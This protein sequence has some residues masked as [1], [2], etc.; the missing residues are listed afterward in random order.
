[1]RRYGALTFNGVRSAKIFA[2]TATYAVVTS[3]VITGSIWSDTRL[4][5]FAIHKR[6]DHV[7]ANRA[8]AKIQCEWE[9]PA[10]HPKTA[11]PGL[12]HARQIATHTQRIGRPALPCFPTEQIAGWP[13][14]PTATAAAGNG[15]TPPPN[16]LERVALV[17]R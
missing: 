2:T 13:K 5:H 4:N 14:R 8:P 1:M 16:P 9:Q 12:L 11:V 3:P 15:S 10:S 7:T 6:T 17:R